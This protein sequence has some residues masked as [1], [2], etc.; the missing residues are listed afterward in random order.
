MK[1]GSRSKSS[2]TPAKGN[3]SQ[4]NTNAQ[5]ILE[6]IIDSAVEI[7]PN[8]KK[9]GGYDVFSKSGKGARFDKNGNLVGFLEPKRKRK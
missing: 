5:K 2:Y 7:I 8:Q 9:Y 1:H 6:E 4:I 3:P